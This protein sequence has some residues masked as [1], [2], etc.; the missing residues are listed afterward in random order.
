MS[1]WG[2]GEREL[3]AALRR[4][5]EQ[6]HQQ[7]KVAGVDTMPACLHGVV[8][9]D[10]LETLRGDLEDIKAELAWI[11]RVIVAAIVTAAL[12]SLLQLGGLG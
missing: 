2:V 4:W 10:G 7:R 6:S 9:Q 3:R 12:G 8:L 5:R 1:E 11:R